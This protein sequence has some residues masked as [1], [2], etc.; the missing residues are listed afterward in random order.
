[1]VPRW[2]GMGFVC[3]KYGLVN[4]V[5]DCEYMDPTKVMA[6]L[7]YPKSDIIA[8]SLAWSMEPKA[9]VKSMNNR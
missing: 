6:S 9:L 2:I 1:M 3:P 8:R 4:V 7:G 5:W